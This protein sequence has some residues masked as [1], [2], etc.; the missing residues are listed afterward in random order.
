[1]SKLGS[2]RL[3]PSFWVSEEPGADK[4][5]LRNSAAEGNTLAGEALVP[6]LTPGTSAHGAEH[7]AKISDPA[8][9]RFAADI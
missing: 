9:T 5:R 8:R 1:M 2:S 4:V 7:D 3:P 6:L